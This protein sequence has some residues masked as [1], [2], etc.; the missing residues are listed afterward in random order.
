MQA[1]AADSAEGMLGP[2]DLIEKSLIWPW[3]LSSSLYG[4]LH[5]STSVW[6]L[7]SPSAS[8]PRKRIKEQEGSYSP[9]YGMASEIIHHHFYLS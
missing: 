6:Q 3:G 8:D 9:S 4:S 1:G 7:A 5:R 2:E